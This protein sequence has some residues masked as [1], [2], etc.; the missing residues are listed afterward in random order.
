MANFRRLFVG[1]AYFR[2]VY[3]RV[4]CCLDGIFPG[5][6]F[7]GGFF[8]GGFCWM[9]CFLDSSESYQEL[10]TQVNGTSPN[11]GCHIEVHK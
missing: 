4:D 3:F 6:F 9:A 7:P 5:G 1:E 2:V 11:E 8:P 10:S